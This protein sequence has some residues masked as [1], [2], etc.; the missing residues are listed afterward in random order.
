M[1]LTGD[2]G[3]TIQVDY[4]ASSPSVVGVGATT[5][6]LTVSGGVASESAW[7]PTGKGGG[8]SGGG[9]SS[10]FARP[11]WQVGTGVPAGAMRLVPDVALAG[12]PNTGAFLI[13]ARPGT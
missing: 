6:M 1:A 11:S 7:S 2:V 3:K 4:P 5:L 13:F 12:D 9:I 10:T 8:S